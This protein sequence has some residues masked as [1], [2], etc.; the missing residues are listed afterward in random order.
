MET[1]ETSKKEL[2][3]ELMDEV[4]ATHTYKTEQNAKI[5]IRLSGE[6]KIG[7]AYNYYDIMGN[8]SLLDAL[9]S[10]SIQDKSLKNKII[11]FIIHNNLLKPYPNT[12]FE[13]AS[14]S[15]RKFF[16]EHRS[17]GLGIKGIKMQYNHQNWLEP[18]DEEAM[19]QENK[20]KHPTYH[21]FTNASGTPI[22]FDKENATK[23]K[24]AIIDE[25]IIPA[26]CIV[27]GAY[28]YVAKDEFSK[29]IEHVKSLKG[30]K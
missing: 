6:E 20:T 8:V 22:K 14:L 28:P 30:G 11:N 18:F 29:Y 9:I 13:Y 7:F 21:I 1:I 5:S 26:R 24:L 23:V 4:Q 19:F 25:G 10:I 17:K 12:T 27:E 2:L 16:N 3:T 15:S